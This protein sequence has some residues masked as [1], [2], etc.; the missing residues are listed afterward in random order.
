MLWVRSYATNHFFVLLS[1][2]LLA[3]RELVGVGGGRAAGEIK[4]R[5]F[6]YIAVLVHPRVIHVHGEGEVRTP[7]YF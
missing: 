5:F 1:L 7:L 2:E 4:S 3:A 6:V